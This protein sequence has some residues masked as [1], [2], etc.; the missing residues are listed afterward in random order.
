MTNYFKENNRAAI[1][2]LSLSNEDIN[3]LEQLN[4]EDKPSYIHCKDEAIYAS[5]GS[6]RWQ[7]AREIRNPPSQRYFTQREEVGRLYR[8]PIARAPIDNFRPEETESPINDDLEACSRAN[9]SIDEYTWTHFL[10]EVN[11]LR[12]L[13]VSDKGTEE[14]DCV[15][16]CTLT[17]SDLLKIISLIIMIKK[18][19]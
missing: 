16:C 1:Q 10:S 6:T 9:M 4:L 2:K 11:V 12:S 15:P 17:L 18:R 5:S 3:A 13:A 14:T 7:R 19:I 8:A